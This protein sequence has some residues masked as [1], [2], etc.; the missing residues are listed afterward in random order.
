MSWSFADLTG[1]LSYI[2]IY[3]LIYLCHCVYKSVGWIYGRECREV[4]EESTELAVFSSVDGKMGV[5][6][7]VGLLHGRST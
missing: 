5:E 7:C 4:A 6:F 1:Y 3:I 2:G